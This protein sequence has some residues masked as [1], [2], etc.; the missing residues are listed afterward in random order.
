MPPN[1]LAINFDNY[2][3]VG[4]EDWKVASVFFDG[5]VQLHFDAENPE[6]FK[7]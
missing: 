7:P 6:D 1:G 3:L 5:S 4:G 2:L